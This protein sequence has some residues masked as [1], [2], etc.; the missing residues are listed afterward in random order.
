MINQ[1]NRDV[2]DFDAYLQIA[3]NILYGPGDTITIYKDKT[4][5]ILFTRYIITMEEL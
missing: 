1:L 4:T 5:L 3:N 2:N